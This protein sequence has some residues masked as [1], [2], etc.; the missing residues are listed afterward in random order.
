MFS[1]IR[2]F[3]LNLIPYLALFRPCRASVRVSVGTGNARYS[4]HAN[5]IDHDGRTHRG[6]SLGVFKTM[7]TLLTVIEEQKE[8]SQVKDLCINSSF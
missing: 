2:V 6:E 5:Y 7:E 8:V 3:H 4:Q 1:S